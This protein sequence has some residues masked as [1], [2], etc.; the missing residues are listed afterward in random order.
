MNLFYTFYSDYLSLPECP[1][2]VYRRT[3]TRQISDPELLR[4]NYI[5]EFFL[6]KCLL[7]IDPELARPLNISTSENGKPFI[8]GWKYHF[9]ISHSNDLLVIAIDDKE[10]GVDCQFVDEEKDY[11]KIANR[12]FNDIDNSTIKTADDFYEL[13][14][15]KE[16]YA[17]KYDI[18][19]NQVLNLDVNNEKYYHTVFNNYHITYC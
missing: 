8:P 15:K 18:P 17:K 2:S 14:T 19:I 6:L 3:K 7:S 4:K 10:I 1:L 9:S 12:F 13:W 11:I 16:A 5:T